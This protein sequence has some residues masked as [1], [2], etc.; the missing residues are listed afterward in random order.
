MKRSYNGKLGVL[1]ACDGIP[2]ILFDRNLVIVDYNSSA[3]EKGFEKFLGK[4][5]AKYMS[6]HEA[7]S[8]RSFLFVHGKSPK[9]PKSRLSR[10]EGLPGGT[11]A[12]ISVKE[13]FGTKFGEMKI[14]RSNS[15]MLKYADTVTALLPGW[16]D[17]SDYIPSQD[18]KSLLASDML[19][20][21]YMKCSREEKKYTGFDIP[22]VLCGTLKEISSGDC[23][24]KSEIAFSNL[25]KKPFVSSLFDIDDFINYI[26]SILVFA[27]SGSENGKIEIGTDF[28]DDSVKIYFKTV[29]EKPYKETTGKISFCDFEEYYPRYA[30]FAHIIEYMSNIF[31][32]LFDV[33]I[34]SDGNFIGEITVDRIKPADASDFHSPETVD[35]ANL[36]EKAFKFASII[37]SF[38]E[39]D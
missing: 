30:A 3:A 22:T 1:A 39:K 12:L 27:D 32:T 37:S 26:V 24:I 19:T 14:F 34:D 4:T 33:E 15:S 5:L 20:K 21:L 31:D 17:T 36:V 23:K 16:S 6:V 7:S 25:D 8:V 2:V 28:S 18:I 9:A 11:R 35:F 38:A 29:F 13:M 10:I